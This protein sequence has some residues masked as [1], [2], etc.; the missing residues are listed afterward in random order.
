[1]RD[2]V[3]AFAY[4]RNGIVEFNLKTELKWDSNSTVNCGFGFV[5]VWFKGSAFGC[6]I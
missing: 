6:V 3:D 4:L 1:M 2:E 5:Y